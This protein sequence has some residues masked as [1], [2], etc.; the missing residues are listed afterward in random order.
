[1]DTVAPSVPTL[2]SPGNGAM[3]RSRVVDFDWSDVPGATYDL[4]IDDYLRREDWPWSDA[5][6]VNLSEG[7][8]TWKVRSVDGV[9]NRS[10]FSAPW[11]VT[12]D[13]ISPALTVASP[14]SSQ[15]LSTTHLPTL[16]IRGTASDVG[17]TG[18]AHV[19][20]NVGSGWQTASGLSNWSYG[21]GL[22]PM[23]EQSHTVRVR[24]WDQAGN[25]TERS[26]SV[27]V[28]TMA[29]TTYD[30]GHDQGTYVNGPVVYSWSTTPDAAGILDYQIRITNTIGYDAVLRVLDPTFTFGGATQEGQE[31]YAWVRARDQRGNWGLWSARSPV[32]IPDLSPPEIT[33]PAIREDSVF[34]H[35]VG[36]QLY[37][38]G[39]MSVSQLVEVTGVS[40]DSVSRPV[41]VEFSRAFGDQPQDV[42]SGF[43]PWSSA[44]P[45]YYGYHVDPGESA[46]GE[47][48]ATVYDAAGNMATQT[49]AYEPDGTPPVSSADAPAYATSAPINVD[50]VAADT[51]S[52]VGHVQLYYNSAMSGGWQPAPEPGGS[53]SGESGTFWFVPPHGNG[54]YEFATRAEDLLGNRETGPLQAQTSTTYDTTKP[55]SEV[56]WAPE[57]AT[58]ST[59]TGTWEA[60][61]SQ[62]PITRTDLWVR[63]VNDSQPDAWTPVK[64]IGTGGT[65]SGTFT[66]DPVGD[67]VYY[68]AAV[69]RDAAG[70]IEPDPHGDGDAHTIRDSEIE[71]PV[72]VMLVQ[73][74][75]WLQDNDFEVVWTH[76]DDLSGIVAAVYQLYP[77]SGPPLDPV[78]EYVNDPPEIDHVH[79]PEEGR[80]TLW[81]W[82]E[83]AAGNVG[84]PAPAVPQTVL[85]Y[86]RTIWSPTALT[87]QPA[88]WSATNDFSVS[89][90]N[91]PDVSGIMGA[92]YKLDSPPFWAE[93]GTW[94]H[95]S[96][97]E[98]IDRLQVPDEGRHTVY[99]WL[100]DVAGNVDHRKWL[101]VDLHYDVSPPEDVAM[102]VPSLTS[103]IRFEVEW[104]ATD[105]HSDI[106]SYTVAVSGWPTHRWEPWLVGTSDTSAIYRATRADDVFDFRVTAYDSA[107]NSAQDEARAGV[108]VQRTYLPF[109]LV[110]SQW[111]PWHK[112][113]IYEQNNT[114]PDAYGPLDQRVAVDSAIWDETDP[115]DFYYFVP[116]SSGQVEVTLTRMPFGDVDL[117][118]I[119]RVRQ[120]GTPDTYPVL[121]SSRNYWNADERIVFNATAGVTYWI[122]VQPY[123]DRFRRSTDP[124]WQPN[125]YRLEWR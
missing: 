31:Y 14:V 54:M 123:D 50:W 3:V 51:Q 49:Y 108:D 110:R 34:L 65:T 59:I 91:P 58:G 70:K 113:D 10:D 71:L 9:G 25:S 79:V 66:Y 2:I 19:E 5:H 95:G 125:S 37:Y 100:K 23:D 75:E 74:Q 60:V 11:Q 72:D 83:D 119:I 76:P 78:H 84:T 102:T 48:V 46:N 20:V 6:I 61:P 88:G 98:R 32:V 96:D 81:I 55:S 56:S 16:T 40:I 64:T 80:Y 115:K 124:D 7:P 87:A 62:A 45:P 15:V 18:L 90:T 8:H 21:W 69:T 17:G 44:Q 1:V 53:G 89:W 63:P 33:Y 122:E 109:G 73:S 4:S 41:R 27:I 104:S 117:D 12:V 86:D 26:V 30:L 116:H 93:D 39:A 35:A 36:L 22:P 111:Q 101:S 42:T 38:T 68:F 103:A 120:P 121:H 106:I 43:A 85:K 77:E 28:D 67:G 94:V 118:L 99:V 57:Y 114:A 13:T 82:L 97:L 52:G 29:P 107:G 24:A 112:M 92:Y 47:I 105:Y